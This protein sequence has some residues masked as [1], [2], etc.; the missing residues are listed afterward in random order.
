VLHTDIHNLQKLLI[1]TSDFHLERTK[2]IFE[3]V[4][5]IAPAHD[6]TLTFLGVPDSETVETELL[7][8]RR[9]K[10]KKR[11]Q[12][13][14][15]TVLT[16]TTLSELHAWLYTEHEAYAPGLTPQRETGVILQGY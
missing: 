2:R 5:S 14:E 13:L 1:I 16:I 4:Y 11:L 8:A 7:E 3:W 6:Y 9:A 15:K 10:E 12:E